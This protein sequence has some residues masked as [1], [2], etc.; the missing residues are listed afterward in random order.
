MKNQV[1]IVSVI[2]LI[3]VFIAVDIQCAWAQNSKSDSVIFFSQVQLDSALKSEV[4][5]PR[6]WRLLGKSKENESYLIAV[7]TKPG[8]V[9]IHE[10]FDD[11]A[12]IRSGHGILRTGFQVTGNKVSGNAPARE[13]LG[14][15]ISNARERKVAPGD[16]IVIPAGL[17]HQYIPD[18]GD[19]LDYIT[20]KV[21]R[22][23]K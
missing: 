14:G 18:S 6:I 17:P 13:W 9:E 21:R 2:A 23:A 22:P 5:P 15:V 8:D 7:R 4:N 12:F 11:V 20:I 3:A 16:F 10:Q 19:A 1:N